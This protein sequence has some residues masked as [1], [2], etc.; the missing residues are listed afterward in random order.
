M[1]CPGTA[2]FVNIPTL[3]EHPRALL[4]FDPVAIHDGDASAA[5]GFARPGHFGLGLI[6][7]AAVRN[8][9]EGWQT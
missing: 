9:G 7:R 4:K 5:D 8:A 1:T 6:W 2:E 3:D